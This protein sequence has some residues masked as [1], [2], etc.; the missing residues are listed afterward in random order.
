MLID[1]DV[2]QMFQ[3]WQSHAAFYRHLCCCF[4]VPPEPP[5]CDPPQLINNSFISAGA[6]KVDQVFSWFIIIDILVLDL[7]K[8]ILKNPIWCNHWGLLFWKSAYAACLCLN[9]RSCTWIITTSE[10]RLA[11]ICIYWLTEVSL[12]SHSIWDESPHTT[13]SVQSWK[14]QKKP[15]LSSNHFFTHRHGFSLMLLLFNGEEGWIS[16]SV[17]QSYS[18]VG[19]GKVQRW[20]VRFNWWDNEQTCNHLLMS[21]LVFSFMIYPVCASS[22]EA[23]FLLTI[24]ILQHLA[25]KFQ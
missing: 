3:K 10:P 22:Q 14:H 2:K 19:V 15:T 16:V 6:L 18:G 21:S 20:W 13:L 12:H 23:R 24:D 7:T 17:L 5:G 8:S 4:T 1:H 25:T 9:Q 11:A